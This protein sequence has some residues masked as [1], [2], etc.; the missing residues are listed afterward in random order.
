MV[1]PDQPSPPDRADA[2][3]LL[4][5]RT[6]PPAEPISCF[7]ALGVLAA[8]CVALG[9]VALALQVRTLG[10]GPLQTLPHSMVV[11]ATG[12]AAFGCASAFQ[13]SI[14]RA[15]LAAGVAAAGLTILGLTIGVYVDWLYGGAPAS[16]STAGLSPAFSSIGVLMA[17]FIAYPAG[18]ALWCIVR[19][20]GRWHRT[21]QRITHA[22]TH[23]RS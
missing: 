10:F 14:P 4:A 15:V 22:D 11:V 17:G 16:R 8:S 9:A 20:A 19:V 12:C 21:A 23:A 7:L 2:T 1:P 6:P 5:S 18:A 3:G 13:R